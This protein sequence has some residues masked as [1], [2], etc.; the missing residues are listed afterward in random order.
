MKRVEKMIKEKLEKFKEKLQKKEEENN[1]KTIENLVVFAIILIVTIVAINYIWSGEEKRE[2][3]DNEE[4]KKLATETDIQNN[5]KVESENTEERLENILS[6]IKGV[7]K[8]KVLLTYSQTSQ[9]MP[10]YDEDSTKSTTEEKDA[11]GG[12]RIVNET[13]TK[14]DIIYEDNNG[15]KMP[16]TQSIVNPKI[17]GAII[18]A[19]GAGDANVKTNI[20]QAVEAVTGLATY[21]IQVFEMKGE[22]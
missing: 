11:G 22:N 16:I 5:E 6:N 7:G 4:N 12:S 9:I 3:S 13:S 1:K 20:I 8:T 15:V 18:T 10:M 19:Q 21:K 14:K 2:E 17:E